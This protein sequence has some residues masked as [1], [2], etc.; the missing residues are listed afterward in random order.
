[1]SSPRACLT[2]KASEVDCLLSV[3]VRFVYFLTYLH[4]TCSGELDEMEIYAPHRPSDRTLQPLRLLHSTM[5]SLY[6]Q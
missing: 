4:M 6:K 3:L 2:V 5:Q 1:M